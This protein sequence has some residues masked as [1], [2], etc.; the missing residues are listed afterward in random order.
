MNT[1]AVLAGKT[2][3]GLKF[4]PDMKTRSGI[5][6]QYLKQIR[7]VLRELC[8]SSI[9]EI[10]EFSR[11]LI[12]A[13][14]QHNEIMFFGTEQD[15]HLINHANIDFLKINNLSIITMGNPEITAFENDCP[16]PYQLKEVLERRHFGKRDVLVGVQFERDDRVLRKAFEYNYENGGINVLISN[17]KRIPEYTGINIS[18]N[19]DNT[20]VARDTAQIV[21]H[22]LSANLAFKTDTEFEDQGAEVLSEYC[23]LLLRSLKGRYFSNKNLAGISALIEK[24]L[25]GES[26][27]FAFG[28]GGNAAIASFTADALRGLTGDSAD[29]YTR[30]FDVTAYVG[31]VTKSINNR[32]INGEIKDDVFTRIIRNLGVKNGDLLLG[33][34]SSGNMKNIL[35]PFVNLDK[36]VR[37]GILGFENGGIVGSSNAADLMAIVL[38]AGGFRSYQRAEDGQR[39]AVSAIINTLY[40]MGRFTDGKPA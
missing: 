39:I 2:K 21:L 14:A 24:K 8:S 26:R 27:I 35:H 9:D 30:I 36:T 12:R 6:E 15:Y 11:V 3:E 16:F 7:N 22:F 23:Q 33:F 13:R 19:S 28:N 40:D 18:I 20:L 10:E 5:I 25:R 32:Y 31:N 4:Y 34:S 38:D 37:I 17:M 29:G 1:N